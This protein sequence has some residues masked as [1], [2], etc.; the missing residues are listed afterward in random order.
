VRRRSHLAAAERFAGQSLGMIEDAT[1]KAESSALVSGEMAEAA[2]Q[3]ASQ[4]QNT[5][6]FASGRGQSSR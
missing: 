1:S 6:E 2:R 4:A 3:A 5:A